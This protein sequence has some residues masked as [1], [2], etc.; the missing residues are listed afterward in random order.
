MK[1][2]KRIKRKIYSLFYQKFKNKS[3]LRLMRKVNDPS[4]EIVRNAIISIIEN[5]LN[6]NELIWIEKIENLRNSLNASTTEIEFIDYGAG[7]PDVKLTS[8]EMYEGRSSTEVISN[9]YHGS[10]PSKWG[11]L[12]LKIIE[13][14]KPAVCLEL[15]TCLG[16]SSSYQASALEMN[17]KG[18]LTTIEGDPT[19][20]SIAKENFEKLGLK[21]VFSEIGRFQDVLERILSNLKQV[22]FA[23]IDG[24]HDEHATLNYFRTIFPY[25]SENAI[26]IF[27]DIEWSKGM[28]RAWN[29]LK[30]DQQI[31]FTINLFKIGICVISSTKIKKR[32][33]KIRLS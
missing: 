16:I 14:F 25:L 24:H 6:D 1:N 23:F 17:K 2:I 7:S 29:A 11:L 4:L 18:N 27:D 26:L 33:F 10:I 3:N 9:L 31:K 12:L 22:N 13:N 32:T 5:R 19:L 8:D 20:A 15:G 30:N 21:R 28:K